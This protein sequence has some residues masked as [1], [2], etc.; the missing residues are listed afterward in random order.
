MGWREEIRRFLR[1]GKAFLEALSVAPPNLSSASRS[2]DYDLARSVWLSCI[3]L[4][5]KQHQ[6]PNRTSTI[7]APLSRLGWLM[8]RMSAM[9]GKL[10]LRCF[11]RPALKPRRT[12]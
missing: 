8:V 6:P 9:D 10:P 11:L 5:Q 4:P 1:V 2:R 12:A 7:D 3:S